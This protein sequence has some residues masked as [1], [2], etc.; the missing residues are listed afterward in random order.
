[1]VDHPVGAVW[2][3]GV[4]D[5][6]L[7]ERCHESLK[8]CAHM[9]TCSFCDSCGGSGSGRLCWLFFLSWKLLVVVVVS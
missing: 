6:L 7:I 9:Y 5:G 8:V 1:M 3:V 4:L 2:Q